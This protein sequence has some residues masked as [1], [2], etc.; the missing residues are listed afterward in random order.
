MIIYSLR[1]LFYCFCVKEDIMKSTVSRK[2]FASSLALLIA[3]SCT[4]GLSCFVASAANAASAVVGRDDEIRTFAF[5]DTT[6]YVTAKQENRSVYNGGS[7]VNA[8]DLVLTASKDFTYKVGSTWYAAERVSNQNYKAVIRPYDDVMVD[9]YHRQ[10]SHDDGM[11]R[12]TSIFLVP[13]NFD[14][15]G[16]YYVDKSIPGGIYDVRRLRSSAGTEVISY[17]T[18]LPTSVYASSNG[19]YS[20]TSTMHTSTCEH[21]LTLDYRYDGSDIYL[22]RTFVKEGSFNDTELPFIPDDGPFTVTHVNGMGA[23]EEIELGKGFAK[24]DWLMYVDGAFSKSQ[25]LYFIRDKSTGKGVVSVKPGTGFSVYDIM[26]DKVE[27]TRL[28]SSNDDM[29]NYSFDAYGS[30]SYYLVRDNPEIIDDSYI[31]GDINRD[32]KVD[33]MDT[34]LLKQYVNKGSADVNK[35]A[36]DPNGDSKTD[37]ND[38]TTLLKFIL[39]FITSIN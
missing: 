17:K 31:A 30:M 5:S 9:V 37:N 27:V 29:D 8:F 19:A 16:D 32:G 33:I 7:V 2:L 14:K 22:V 21:T 39:K 24:S 15:Q 34:V 1:A 20:G 4:G 13:E 28:G 36:L 18:L 25:V 12:K 26:G 38:V 35:R 10:V 6:G 23:E 3:A 11:G